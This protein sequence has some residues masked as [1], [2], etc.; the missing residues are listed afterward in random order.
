MK[1]R[2]K[3]LGATLAFFMALAIII[4]NVIRADNPITVTVDGQPVAFVDQEPV[5]IDGYVLA[6]VRG[7][8]AQMGF[9]V[10]WNSVQRTA[11][12]SMDD[13]VIIIPIAG[14]TFTVNG[15][16]VIPPVPQR[17]INGR[18]MLPLRAIAEAVGGRADWDSTNR[19]AMIILNG[20]APE[21]M[22]TPTPEAT[23]ATTPTPA[24][25]VTPTPMPTP[26]PVPTPS[27]V[28]APTPVPTPTPTPEP[29]TDR[30][31]IPNRRL[32]ADEIAQWIEEYDAQGGPNAFELEVLR[33]VN[34]ERAQAGVNPLSMNMSMMMAARFK[35]QSMVDL[36]YFSHTSP[37]Y[38][39]F[40]NIAQVL[41]NI[42][43]WAENLAMGQRSPETVVNSWMTSPGHRAN[44]LNT[45]YTEIGI[46]YFEGRWTQKF[47]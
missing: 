13:T 11:I 2:V 34:E 40:N 5:I 36:G 33:L 26:T 35:S 23:P 29:A 1:T 25:Q 18:L 47:R 21:A 20:E 10:N 7:V 27:P 16:T 42:D 31:V 39:Q 41:F 46:G 4:P 19:V 22:P 32:T 8:F 9:T 24:P 28:T 12:L 38:G 3:M 17:V 45:R 15:A 6:P 30:M 43:V 14:N 44:I 37:V